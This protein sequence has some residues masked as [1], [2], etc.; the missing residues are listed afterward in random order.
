MAL[1]REGPPASVADVTYSMLESAVARMSAALE[2]AAGAN[3]AAVRPMPTTTGSGPRRR[4]GVLGRPAEATDAGLVAGIVS[5]VE[6]ALS[7]RWGE[8]R[9]PRVDVDGLSAFLA[10]WLP[11]AGTGDVADHG[12]E[13]R[14]GREPDLPGRGQAVRDRAVR[15]P[16][17]LHSQARGTLGGHQGG[18]GTDRPETMDIRNRVTRHP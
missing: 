12:V 15:D 4:A 5:D 10:A 14:A 11:H 8:G 3:V 2:Q 1:A 13:R 16:R 6:V 7:D 17:G 9:P 18:V